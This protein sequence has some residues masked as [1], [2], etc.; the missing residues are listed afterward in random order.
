MKLNKSNEISK[1]VLYRPVKC[2]KCGTKKV[3]CYGS[4]FPIR[5]YKCKICKYNFKTKEVEQ[6]KIDF[7]RDCR[8]A[9]EIF[10]KTKQERKRKY[11]ESISGKNSP[12]WKGGRVKD[13]RGY[14]WIKAPKG[15][16]GAN[17][18]GYIYEH[19]L[20][21]EKHLGRYLRKEEVIRHINNN[22]SDNRLDNLKLCR[23]NNEHLKLHKKS[24]SV[25]QN[26]SIDK[27]IE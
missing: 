23:N 22:T 6:N 5:Y 7:D 1:I 18:W 27:N 17:L 21:I 11:I 16:L 4:Y 26:D 8:I 14:V 3:H 20:I 15:H 19:R 25:I 12:N 24:C 9:F 10:E 13:Y 2:P